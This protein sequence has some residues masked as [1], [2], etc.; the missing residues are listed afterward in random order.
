METLQKA[1][2]SARRSSFGING[3]SLLDFGFVVS[4]HVG[5]CR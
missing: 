1:V 4:G 2:S 5:R 3:V